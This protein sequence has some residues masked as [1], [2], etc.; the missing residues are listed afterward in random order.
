LKLLGKLRDWWSD[1]EDKE[2]R[3][4]SRCFEEQYGNFT[5]KQLAK[6]LEDLLGFR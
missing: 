4:R 1:N 3:N 6:M 5:V 2:F